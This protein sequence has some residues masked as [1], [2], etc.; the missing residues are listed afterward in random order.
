MVRDQIGAGPTAGASR[1]K[2]DTDRSAPHNHFTAVPDSRVTIP[3]KGS[4]DDAG[5][6][7][8][9]CSGIVPAARVQNV[10]AIIS[11]PHDHLV[12]CPD[13]CVLASR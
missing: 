6:H 7:P 10:G 1:L 3:S 5:S 13:C 12:A 2:I 11:R 4:I 8:A 9:V